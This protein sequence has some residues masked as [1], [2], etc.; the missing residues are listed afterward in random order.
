MLEL[1]GVDMDEKMIF[2]AVVICGTV[3]NAW[4]ILNIK[5]QILQLELRLTNKFFAA[6]KEPE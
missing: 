3:A 1:R 5:N 4:M 2:E 6:K